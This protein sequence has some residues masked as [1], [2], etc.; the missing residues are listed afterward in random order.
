MGNLAKIPYVV[1]ELRVFK[2]YQ[3][4]LILKWALGISNITWLAVVIWLL[5]R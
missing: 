1:H 2:A 4:E 3:R 5:V